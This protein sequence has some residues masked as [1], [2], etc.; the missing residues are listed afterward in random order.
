MNWEKSWE[1]VF[2]IWAKPPS[3]IEQK[4]WVRTRQAVN[5]AISSSSTL[6][7]RGIEVVTHG[8][9]RNHTIIRTDSDVDLCVLCTYTC[10]NDNPWSM[11]HEESVLDIYE[12]KDNV[13]YG[14]EPKTYAY[15]VYKEEVANAL[16][17]YFGDHNVSYG[18][19]AIHVHA[20]SFQVDADIVA[21]Y[22]YHIR[23][24][25]RDY[26]RGIAFHS[27]HYGISINN[28]PYQHYKNAIRKN[29]ETGSRFK[30]VVRILKYLRNKIIEDT[31]SLAM[32]LPSFL[33]ECL[34]WNVPNKAF[35]NNLYVED[36]ENV[37]SYLISETDEI[38]KHKEWVEINNLRYLFR[39]SQD[40]NIIQIKDFLYSIVEYMMTNPAYYKLE[41]PF[42]GEILEDDLDIDQAYTDQEDEE[43]DWKDIG[44]D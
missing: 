13:E 34:V 6:Q 21:C 22:R 32:Y 40:W 5:N 12:T 9:Y 16:V 14:L 43:I 3:P 30:S 31:S 1:E 15:D 11:K 37:I 36:I 7:N 8:S 42:P 29:K 44:L 10:I 19:K 33:I 20:T 18:D 38:G 24:K 26:L 27:K 25:D 39:S 17:N 35:N 23:K 28:W 2:R 41:Y 4:K